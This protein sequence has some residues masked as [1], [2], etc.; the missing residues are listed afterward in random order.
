MWPFGK[1]KWVVVKQEIQPS[2]MEVLLEKGWVPD[3]TNLL[4]LQRIALIHYRDELSGNEKVE[5]ICL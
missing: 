5:R 3:R 2:S 4:M 1:T